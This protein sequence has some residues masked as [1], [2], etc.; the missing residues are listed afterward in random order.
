MRLFRQC[1]SCGREQA[2]QALRC[3]CGALLAGVDLSSAEEPAAAGAPPP[4][5]LVPARACAPG[6][7]AAGNP[8]SGP[9]AAA[10]ASAGPGP[11]A[12]GAAGGILCAH[13]DCGQLNPPGSLRCRYCDRPLA[14]ASLLW[15]WGEQTAIEDE[16][17]VGRE[18]PAPAALIQRLE[19]QFDNVSRQHALLRVQEGALWIED[20]ASTNGTFI[21]EVRLAAR[22]PVRV[23]DGACLRFAA[24]LMAT[25]H[26]RAD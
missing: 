9:A 11:A 5:P 18:A 13:A 7:V 8:A 17:L 2:P 1:P 19:A 25:A 14:R 12:A 15:P 24:K 16:L 10:P 3:A 6:A 23:R 22:Q 20:L 26:V 21:D 4:A